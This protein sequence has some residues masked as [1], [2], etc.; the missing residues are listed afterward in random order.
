MINDRLCQ[1][2]LEELPIYYYPQ[3]LSQNEADDLLIRLRDVSLWQKEYLVMFGKTVEVPRL[4]MW[5]G[6][7]EARYIY[8]GVMHEPKPWLPELQ[9]LKDRL[10]QQFDTDFNSVLGN[11][12]RSGKDYMGWHRDNEAALGRAPTI[13]SVSLG[14]ER[15]F[16]L[17]HRKTKKLFHLVLE[18]GSLLMMHGACQQDWEHC[19]PKTMRQIEPRINLTFRRIY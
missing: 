18:H 2:R 13:A 1:V 9:R 16:S 14:A 5:I 17:R 19:L 6:D 10:K 4:I 8:S 11:L 7:A 15:K 12:Y 3:W